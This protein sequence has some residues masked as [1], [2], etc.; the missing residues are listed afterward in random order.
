MSDHPAEPIVRFVGQATGH[1]DCTVAALAMALGV[2]YEQALVYMA[3]VQ[4]SV[5]K[6]GCSWREVRRAAKHHGA[7]LVE[8]RK[9]SLE[10]DSEDAGILNVQFNDG[11]HHAVYFKHGL[12]FDGRTNAAWEADVYLAAHNATPTT[13]LVRTK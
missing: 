12:I 4:P 11:T 3:R 1:G 9:F 13:L 5:L 10:E 6:T 2:S 7:T 8:R